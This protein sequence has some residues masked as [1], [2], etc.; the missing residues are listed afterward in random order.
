MNPEDRLIVALDVAEPHEAFQLT[1]QLAGVARWVKVGSVLFS[2]AGRSLVRKLVDDG[3]NVFLDLKLHDVPHQVS[4]TVH[5][6]SDLGVK[7]ATLH[8][9]GGPRMMEAAAEA[10]SKSAAT[11]LKLLG[12]TVL[13]SMDAQELRSVGVEGTPAEVVA[14]RARLAHSSGLDGVVSSAL[15][16]RA[17]RNIVGDSF[18]IVTPGTGDPVAEGEVGDDPLERLVG[19]ATILY[20][21]RP[22]HWFLGVWK[23]RPPAEAEWLPHAYFDT[24]RLQALLAAGSLTPPL[25][26]ETEVSVQWSG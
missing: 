2:L 22:Q 11:D 19:R 3:W 5:A 6:L 20:R 10:A 7:L 23:D 9:S 26:R 14:A 21:R 24:P 12:V 1:S 16:A 18:E 8:T 17:I 15:E 4:M 25:A 13:T